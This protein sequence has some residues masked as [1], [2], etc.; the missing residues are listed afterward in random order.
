MR[1]HRRGAGV[2]EDLSS[3]QKGRGA[4]RRCEST[5]LTSDARSRTGMQVARYSR[6]TLTNHS[7]ARTDKAC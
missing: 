3:P 6:L 5:C 1:G 7:P 4:Q 2:P